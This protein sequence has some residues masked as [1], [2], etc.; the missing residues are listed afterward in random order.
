MF[1]ISNLVVFPS[2]HSVYWEQVAGQGIPMI[3]KRWKGIEHINLGG[4]VLFLDEVSEKSM[5]QKIKSVIENAEL[6]K[7]MEE[8][9]KL[10]GKEKFSYKNIAK[11][12][13]T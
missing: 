7:V 8:T 6:Y 12:S 10:K 1:A 3:V 9:A 13:I 5:I 2:T 11:K 4:N